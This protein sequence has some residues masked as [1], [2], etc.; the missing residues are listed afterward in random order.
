M[1]GTVERLGWEDV[2]GRGPVSGPWCGIPGETPAARFA[3]PR[4]LEEKE[5]TGLGMTNEI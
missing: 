2:G 5:E 1:D 3:V 4:V